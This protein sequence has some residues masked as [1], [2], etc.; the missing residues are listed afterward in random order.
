MASVLSHPAAIL[1]LS[2]W[3]RSRGV[4]RRAALFGVFCAVLPDVDA[5]G[6]WLGVPYGSAWGHRGLTHSILAAAVVAA[7]CAAGAFRA[8]R[9]RI[10]ILFFLFLCGASHGFF[11]AMTDGGLGVAFLAP[12]DRGRFFLPW[13]PVRVSPIG[14]HGFFG[15]RGLA[16]LESE[17]LWI[18]LPCVAL[19]A[20]GVVWR[21]TRMAG[22]DRWK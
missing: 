12:F 13:R 16:I 6:F 9:S 22:G 4:R 7:A 18:W 10:A 21:R 15:P 14:L 1:G 11:D 19:G 5:V 3:F 20:A 8:E 17:L 2:P